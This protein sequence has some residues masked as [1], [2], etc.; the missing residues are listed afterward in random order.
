MTKI[1]YP[2]NFVLFRRDRENWYLRQ[3]KIFATPVSYP[4]G[5]LIDRRIEFYGLSE[6]KLIGEF[7]WLNGGKEGYYLANLEERQYYYCGTELEDVKARLRSLGI[8]RNDPMEK[9]DA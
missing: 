2:S 4:V 8:G 9:A 3:S 1:I 6:S 5:E 7:L